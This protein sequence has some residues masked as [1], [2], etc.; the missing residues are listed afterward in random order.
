MGSAKERPA[1]DRDAKQKALTAFLAKKAGEEKYEWTDSQ[2]H[3]AS[4]S[5]RFIITC[6]QNDTPI[7]KSFWETLKRYAAHN[8]AELLVI[9]S[10]YQTPHPEIQ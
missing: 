9:P 5:Q 8:E 10:R 2:K 4:K 1:R 3:A 6:A 7:H